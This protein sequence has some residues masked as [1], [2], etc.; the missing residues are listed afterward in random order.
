[1]PLER[2]FL[3]GDRSPHG[4]GGAAA[5]GHD[6]QELKLRNDADYRGDGIRGGMEVVLEHDHAQAGNQMRAELE[7]S[8]GDVMEGFGRIQEEDFDRA[9]IPLQLVE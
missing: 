3:E 5:T 1:M 4:E 6:V 8:P 7:Q 9:A 2:R